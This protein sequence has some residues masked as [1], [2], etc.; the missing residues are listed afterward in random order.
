MARERDTSNRL[1]FNAS[2]YL[3]KRW[4]GRTEC[5]PELPADPS[6]TG[7]VASQSILLFISYHVV[8]VH[9]HNITTSLAAASR[10][11]PSR[12]GH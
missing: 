5:S 9:H 1:D 3:N 8:Y 10:L 11:A 2:G 6:R 7:I 12:T 4:S